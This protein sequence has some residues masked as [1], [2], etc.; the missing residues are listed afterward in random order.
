M[1]LVACSST[2]KSSET[3]SNQSEKENSQH[4]NEKVSV[5][6]NVNISTPESEKPIPATLPLNKLQQTEYYSPILGLAEDYPRG[7]LLDSI[8]KDFSLM[9]Q[10]GVS[11]IRVSVAW[12]DYERNKHIFDWGLLDK[13]VELAEQYGIELYPYICYSPPWATGSDWKAPPK[14]YQDWYDFVYTLVDRYKGKINQW[15]LW[16]EGDNYDFWT[17]S[18]GEQIE[19][20]KVGAQAVKDANPNARTVFGGLTDLKKNHVRSI[21][22]D[23]AADNIDVINIHFYNETWNPNATERIYDDIKIVADVIRENGGKQELWIAEIGYSDY[24]QEDGIKVSDWVRKKAPYEK[25]KEFQAV[26]FMR[27]YSL[28][29][30]TE[31]VST[32]LWYEI[33]NL[34]LNSEAIGDVNNYFLGALDHNYFPK[35]LW[36]SIAATKQLF[37]NPFITID[38]E[39][40]IDQKDAVKPYVHAF[41]RENGDVILMAWNRGTEDETIEVTVPGNFSKAIRYSVTGEKTPFEFDANEDSTTLSLELKPEYTNT[42]ELIK[43]KNAPARVTISN[44]QVIK[45]SGGIYTVTAMAT[46]IG[47]EVA[48]A[49]ISEIFVNE[50]LEVEGDHIQVIEKIK[51]G[52][53]IELS[54]MVERIESKES[55]QLWIAV[56]PKES[57]LAAVLVEIE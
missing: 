48:V 43:A 7:T 29:A 33:K 24:V 12:G 30:A 15:E 52:E 13:Y 17:G 56:N 32:I 46:N 42:I 34:R 54:W 57:P 19:L 11:D 2:P 27:A 4:E 28:I 50:G 18:W 25:T 20:V 22:K 45:E 9:N 8:E 16:N 14:D 6:K 36:F 41:K 51:P 49:I 26:T 35:H 3:G 55:P 38:D 44:P 39:L 21:F 40:V 37:S 10:Y 23:G 47:D 31:D 53:E 1:L 5:D